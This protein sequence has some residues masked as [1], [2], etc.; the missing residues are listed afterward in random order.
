MALCGCQIA[1]HLAQ[2][3]DPKSKETKAKISALIAG[4]KAVALEG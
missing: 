3:M 1:Q 4:Y 2:K